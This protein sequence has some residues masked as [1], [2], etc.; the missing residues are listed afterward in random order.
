MNKYIALGLLIVLAGRAGAGEKRMPGLR[1]EFKPEVGAWAEY[2]YSE[3]S[4]GK[5]K[6]SAR[7]KISVVG[8]E[9]EFYW[10]EQHFAPQSEEPVTM[11]MLVGKAAAKPKK[12]LIK[13]EEGVMDMTRFYGAMSPGTS[14]EDQGKMKEAGSETVSVPAGKFKARK[15]TY[16][17]KSE[18]GSVWMKAGVGPYGL[19]QQEVS[20][21]KETTRMVL[22]SYGKGA[23]PSIG[24]KADS[25]MP[26]MPAGMEGGM[27]DMKELMKKAMQEAGEGD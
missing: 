6:D 21:K 15:M 19:I 11:K 25:A 12:I 2:E 27:P 18:N 9:G 8:K 22:H 1:G 26:D 3:D 14:T 5:K 24:N 7:F 17:D 16:E 13:T 23:K 10:I 20:S 4:R